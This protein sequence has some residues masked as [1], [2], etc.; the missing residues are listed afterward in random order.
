MKYF[1][2][3]HTIKFPEENFP[4][5]GE[6]AII[7]LLTVGVEEMLVGTARGAAGGTRAHNRNVLLQSFAP[8]PQGAGAPFHGH[9]MRRN[10]YT[11]ACVMAVD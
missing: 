1:S 9:G 6:N 4:G 5:N 3:N 2:C 10:L 7:T 8:G 11:R